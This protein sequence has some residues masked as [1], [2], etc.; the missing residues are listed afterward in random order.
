MCTS[1]SLT[2]DNGQVFW[3]RTMDLNVGVFEDDAGLPASIVNIPQGATI[4]SNLHSWT[5]KYDVMGIG[6]TKNLNIFDGVNSAGLAGD[7]QVLLESTHATAEQLQER[8]LKPLLGEEFVTFV[9]SNFQSVAEI[10]EHIQEYGLLYHPYRHGYIRSQFSGHYLFIDE[11]NDSVVIEPTDQGA[12]RLYDSVGVMTNSPEYYWHITNLR[13][14]INLSNINPHKNKKVYND[15]LALAPIA[16]GT[17]YGMLGLPGDYTSPSRFVRAA[18]IADSL[19]DFKPEAGINQLFSVLKSVTVPQGV[20]RGYK[21][22]PVSDH[23]RYWV[24]YDLT[25]RR[26]YVQ[27]C[28][29][30]AF[31]TS[32]LKPHRSQITRTKI[33][34]SNQAIEL[35]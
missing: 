2:A 21:S 1:I 22:S 33:Q 8:H 13:N 34:V 27:T 17:G 5:S 29:G 28:L 3:G 11:T 15:R 10:R 12:F 24:G 4:T 6:S 32:K 19:G 18:L 14:Y 7:L 31:N 30:L 9:L 20:Q 35:D 25:E 16:T 23:T 26:L